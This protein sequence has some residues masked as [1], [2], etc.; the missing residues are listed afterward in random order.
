MG[1]EDEISP[2][3]D[4]FRV[5]VWDKDG[6]ISDYESYAANAESAISRDKMILKV[7]KVEKLD[8]RTKAIRETYY[9]E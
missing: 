7:M 2:G 6:R 8:P 9:Y 3:Y 5:T 1:E 4:L